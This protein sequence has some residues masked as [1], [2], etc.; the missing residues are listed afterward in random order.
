MAEDEKLKTE[1][2]DGEEGQ[3]VEEGEEGTKKGSKK[4]LIIIILIIVLLGGG[5]AGAYFAGLI[6]M[7]GGGSEEEELTPEE[8]EA[9]KP[10]ITYYDLEKFVVNLNNPGKQVSFL[11]MEITLELPNTAMKAVIDSKKPRIRDTFQVYLRELRS[12]DLQGSAAL[13]RLR[14]E[15]LLRINKTLE[16]DEVND[17]L[18]KE[19]I[20]Q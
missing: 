2:V 16:P 12:T 10:K 5:G 4:K 8:I 1:A 14:E 18:F 17:I 15:L 3:D 11:K 20:V 19:I 9:Q 13:H 7:G 6:P